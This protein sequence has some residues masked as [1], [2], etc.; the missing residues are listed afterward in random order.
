MQRFCTQIIVH[1]NSV[2]YVPILLSNEVL[3]CSFKPM[4]KMRKKW[5]FEIGSLISSLFI[6]QMEREMSLVENNSE[7]LL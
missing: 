6:E 2:A 1:F 4:K 7:Q 5:T 3:R